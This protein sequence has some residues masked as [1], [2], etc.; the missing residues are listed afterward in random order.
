MNEGSKAVSRAMTA[1]VIISILLILLS[2]VMLMEVGEATAIAFLGMG[3][4][5]FI[6][7][8]I[9][10]GFRSIVEASELYKHRNGL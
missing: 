6:L 4:C 1:V 3:I 7:N 2:L 5:G 8:A 9:L 10:K